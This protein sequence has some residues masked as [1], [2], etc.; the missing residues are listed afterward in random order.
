MAGGTLRNALIYG[1]TDYS[2]ESLCGTVN[3]AGGKLLNCTVADNI[4]SRAA[5]PM[6]RVEAGA[7]A[8]NVISWNN[9]A[10]P[11]ISGAGT[12]SHCCYA[13]AAAGN[14]NGNVADAPLFRAAATRDYTLRPSSPCRNAGS[15][16]AFDAVADA[17]DL[18]GLPRLFGKVIDIGCHELQSGAGTLLFLQ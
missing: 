13:N 11:D 14:A 7:S 6:V 18:A 15:N 10:S 5:I 16:A 8:V 1:C 3:V 17:T 2:G 4:C 12:V 9:R